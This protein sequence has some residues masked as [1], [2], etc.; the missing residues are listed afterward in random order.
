MDSA[1]ILAQIKSLETADI[2]PDNVAEIF[3]HTVSLMSGYITE[4]DLRRLILIGAAMYRNSTRKA[5]AELQMPVA[6]GAVMEPF[7]GGKD[8][9]H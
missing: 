7:A 5:G 6:E 3:A 4:A 9:L 2:D 1:E 8:F